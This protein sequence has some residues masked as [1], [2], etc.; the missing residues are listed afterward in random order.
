MP[1]RAAAA[2]EDFTKSR[3][4]VMTSLWGETERYDAG[5]VSVNRAVA[6][7]RWP[8]PDHG[9][10]SNR[11]FG[12]LASVIGQRI[13]E[14]CYPSISLSVHPSIYFLTPSATMILTLSAVFTL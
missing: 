9:G 10:P 6:G 7:A 1:S 3:L 2:A 12:P 5:R 8:M 13:S 11:S 4:V 14:L